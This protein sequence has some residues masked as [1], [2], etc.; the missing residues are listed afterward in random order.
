MGNPQSEDVAGY[1][2][3]NYST[4]ISHILYMLTYKGKKSKQAWSG[5]KML[6]KQQDIIKSRRKKTHLNALKL[7]T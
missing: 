4:E 3:C 6:E 2:W 5:K 1:F 7:R